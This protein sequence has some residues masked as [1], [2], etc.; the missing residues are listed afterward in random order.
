MAF[1]NGGNVGS[2]ISGKYILFGI[3]A[4]AGVVVLSRV[5]KDSRPLMVGATKEMIAFKQWLEASK[6]E[7]E[8][9]IEDITEEAKYQYKNEVEERLE[10][11][12][13]QQEILMKLKNTLNKE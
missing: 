8:E 10:I 9:F 4:V 13:K 1:F 6:A 7:T 2:C 3:G 11:L 12:Q 5:L